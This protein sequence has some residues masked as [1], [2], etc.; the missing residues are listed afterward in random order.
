MWS[1]PTTG[2]G[3]S[4]SPVRSSI[5][6]STPTRSESPAAGEDR[7]PHRPCR[8]PMLS[9]LW[10]GPPGTSCAA[11]RIR[12]LGCSRTASSLRRP[13]TSSGPDSPGRGATRSCRH[14]AGRDDRIDGD[15]HAGQVAD[16][17]DLTMLDACGNGP[18]SQCINRMLAMSTPAPAVSASVAGTRGLTSSSDGRPSTSRRT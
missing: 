17:G 10:R 1:T 9:K 7:R 6:T 15:H 5:L 11:R 2:S 16:Y 4:S 14:G 3:E 8:V 13:R 18:A 12:P